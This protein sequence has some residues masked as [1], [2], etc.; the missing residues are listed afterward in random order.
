MHLSNLKSHGQSEDVETATDLCAYD[1]SKQTSES[2]ADIEIENESMQQTPSK[3]VDFYSTIE[4]NDPTEVSPQ[5]HHSNSRG[6]NY[7]LRPNA[8]P[9]YSE[10]TPIDVCNNFFRPF[11]AQFP[12]AI[13]TFFIIF[14]HTHHSFS[15][16]GANPYK[17]QTS[18]VI[19]QHVYSTINKTKGNSR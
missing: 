1:T 5:N 13:L 7:N 9:N 19:V 12:F 18:T 14:P 2:R 10:C 4:V 8:K 17:N 6:G 16:S 3:H 11:S 15:V